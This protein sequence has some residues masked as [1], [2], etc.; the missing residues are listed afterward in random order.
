MGAHPSPVAGVSRPRGAWALRTQAT[1]FSSTP[2]TNPPRVATQTRHGLPVDAPVRGRTRSV[3]AGDQSNPLGRGA[4]FGLGSDRGV[5]SLTTTGL[6]RSPDRAA[7]QWGLT[8]R[9]GGAKARRRARAVV[10]GSPQDQALVQLGV[11]RHRHVRTAP[12]QDRSPDQALRRLAQ[13]EQVSGL[14]LHLVEGARADYFAPPAPLHLEGGQIVTTTRV[15]GIQ[16]RLRTAMAVLK[17]LGGPD[18]TSRLPGTS[19]GDRDSSLQTWFAA[20]DVF[21]VVELLVGSDDA[22]RL[23]ELP[24]SGRRCHLAS[25]ASPVAHTRQHRRRWRCLA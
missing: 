19:S 13:L 23:P 10:V 18:L 25:S 4:S 11:E 12:A 5:G 6:R 24:D 1:R 16:A 2:A 20:E 22:T 8:G 21:V 7:S 9:R 14:L 15:L 17:E 3:E